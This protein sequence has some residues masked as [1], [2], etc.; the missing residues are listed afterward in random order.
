MGVMRALPLSCTTARLRAVG[1]LALLL[2]LETLTPVAEWMEHT[3]NLG[4]ALSTLVAAALGAALG[5]VGLFAR[6]ALGVAAHA[7]LAAFV[8]ASV[9]GIVS[10]EAWALPRIGPD[11]D[12]VLT[13][14]IAGI[15]LLGAATALRRRT[16]TAR[17]VAAAALLSFTALVGLLAG[18]TET[19]L[20]IG[21][22]AVALVTLEAPDPTAIARPRSRGSARVTLPQHSSPRLP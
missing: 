6:R 4:P 10:F 20:A 17:R 5:W 11:P 18:S 2:L 9:G 12:H 1:S 16:D 19:L 7:V 8:A 22:T 13:T 3:L 21:A 14:V 15:C